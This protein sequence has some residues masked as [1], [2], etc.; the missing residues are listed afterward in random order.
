MVMTTVVAG[1]HADRVT[2]PEPEPEVSERATRRTYPPRT[3]CGSWPTTSGGAATSEAP[4][5][6]ARGCIPRRSRSGA[7]VSWLARNCLDWYQLLELAAAY[8]KSSWPV[9]VGGSAKGFCRALGAA[10]AVTSICAHL[11]SRPIADV[12]GASN[13]DAPTAARL[14]PRI[15]SGVVS[16]EVGAFE[17][18]ASAGIVR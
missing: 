17:P 2:E 18:E 9:L 1:R 6:A 11:D 12:L 13:R 4:C 16:R 7:E 5:C 3:S 14:G 15:V 10:W 8:I